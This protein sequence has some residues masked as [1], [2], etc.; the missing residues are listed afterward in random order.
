MQH[1]RPNERKQCPTERSEGSLLCFRRDIR[2]HKRPRPRYETCWDLQ[3]H[4]LSSVLLIR[5]Y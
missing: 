2:E 5:E 1:N 4:C 3:K